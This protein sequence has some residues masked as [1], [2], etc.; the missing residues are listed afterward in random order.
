MT[1]ELFYPL[2][3]EAI[4]Y[5]KSSQPNP[6]VVEKYSKRCSPYD[7]VIILTVAKEQSAEPTVCSRMP[8]LKK[9]HQGKKIAVIDSKRNS[10]ARG[11]LS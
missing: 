7:K 6:I 11:C 10:G 4:E 5:P 8:F 9:L 2:L 1:P 3:E